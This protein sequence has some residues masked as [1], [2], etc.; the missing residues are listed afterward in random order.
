MNYIRIFTI[1]VDLLDKKAAYYAIVVETFS[2]CAM[3]ELAQ[4]LKKRALDAY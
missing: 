3:L 4:F 1:L 2:V